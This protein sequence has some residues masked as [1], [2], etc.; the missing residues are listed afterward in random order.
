VQDWLTQLHDLDLYYESLRDSLLRDTEE[1]IARWADSGIT[2]QLVIGHR[3]EEALRRLAAS[4]DP[5]YA[6]GLM[7]VDVAQLDDKQMLQQVR[8]ENAERKQLSAVEQLFYIDEAYK[9]LGEGATQKKVAA[10]FNM[11]PST[12]RNLCR[13]KDLPDDVAAANVSGHLGQTLCEE[14][15]PGIRLREHLRTERELGEEATYSWPPAKPSVFIDHCLENQVSRSTIQSYIDDLVSSAGRAIPPQYLETDVAADGVIQPSCKRCP[16]AVQKNCFN[17]DCFEIKR[18]AVARA[19]AAERLPNIAWS[20]DMKDF[21]QIPASALK[22]IIEENPDDPNL[23]VGVYCNY[24]LRPFYDQMHATSYS[25]THKQIAY[26]YKGEL[27][28]QPSDD[29]PAVQSPELGISVIDIRSSY[30]AE[31]NKLKDRITAHYTEQARNVFRRLPQWFA[32]TL[33]T[34]YYNYDAAQ[35]PERIGDSYT[36]YYKKFLKSL[37]VFEPLPLNGLEAALWAI[38]LWPYYESDWRDCYTLFADAGWW[39]TISAAELPDDVQ[40]CV[41]YLESV[42]SVR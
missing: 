15:L 6:C 25:D 18:Y 39:D 7:P 24:A 37:T 21:S 28:A 38:N 29:A 40:K 34:D 14:L 26:G 17:H 11:N 32:S 1:L 22:Q 35:T 23:V 30:N 5:R 41:D 9:I 31:M 2:A 4:G 20:D 13:L 33:L 19:Y 42:C 27:P 3:R 12:F 8:L 10:F 36:R 16:A